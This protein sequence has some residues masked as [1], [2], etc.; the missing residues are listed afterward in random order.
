[1]FKPLQS[2]HHKSKSAIVILLSLCFVLIGSC[3]FQKVVTGYFYSQIEI[4]K[5]PKATLNSSNNQTCSLSDE[6][7]KISILNS[8]KPSTKS[9]FHP[10]LLVAAILS[11]STFFFKEESRS[12]QRKRN[13]S[14]VTP[15]PLFLKH[16]VLLI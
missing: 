9:L 1:M 11:I 3:S 12:L 6:T 7:V 15:F 14:L 10:L 5:Q 4:S 16:R 2:I 8:E 13:N